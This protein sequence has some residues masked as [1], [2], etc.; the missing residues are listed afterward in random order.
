MQLT[1]A[2]VYVVAEDDTPLLDLH[3][4]QIAE[5]T[6]VPYTIYAGVN[7]LLP[8]FQDVLTV[9]SEVRIC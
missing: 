7:R 3:L 9:R 5:N 8:Q 2:V 4:N 1:V 6:H